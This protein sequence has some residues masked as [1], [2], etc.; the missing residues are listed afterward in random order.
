[1]LLSL[2][3]LLL[4]CVFV[5]WLA[6]AAIA[7]FDPPPPFE[8]NRKITLAQVGHKGRITMNW[9]VSGYH[10]EAM[11]LDVYRERSAQ[12]LELMKS[13]TVRGARGTERL[14]FFKQMPIGVYRLHGIP[15]D[16]EGQPVPSSARPVYL[17]YGGLK[18]WRDYKGTTK[19]TSERVPFSQGSASSPEQP[20]LV[21]EPAGV[22]VNAGQSV[23]L[24]AQLKGFQKEEELVWKL[25]GQGDLEQVSNTQVVYR[26]DAES[27]S[28]RV[29]TIRVHVKNY[30]PMQANVSVVVTTAT[31]RP[32][33]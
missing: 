23:G 7:Q 29:A 5:L 26:C 9:D 12:K 24:T 2:R 15:L 33:P 13:W 17:E 14:D 28:G 8:I 3:F 25:E 20:T 18:A 22:V 6:C 10:A 11:R 27:T 32:Q 30:P 19:D 31:V 1:M 16:A 4:V 21:V